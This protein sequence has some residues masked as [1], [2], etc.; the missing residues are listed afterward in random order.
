M[1][2]P[3]DLE[4]LVGFEQ[5]AV[6]GVGDATGDLLALEPHRGEV[7]VSEAGDLQL[8]PLDDRAGAVADGPSADA[9]PLR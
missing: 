3:E 9:R 8:A 6:C 5:E 2:L 1:G 4:Q 7:A